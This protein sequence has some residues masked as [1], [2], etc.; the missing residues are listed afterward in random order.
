MRKRAPG[1]PVTAPLRDDDA[2]DLV[3]GRHEIIQRFVTPESYSEPRIRLP[4]SCRYR[5]NLPLVYSL[6]GAAGQRETSP[7]CCWLL[8]VL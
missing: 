8:R 7:R 4:T 6:I 3:S 1:G 2:I 5:P